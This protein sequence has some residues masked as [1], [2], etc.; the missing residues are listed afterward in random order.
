MGLSKAGLS[1]EEVRAF[2]GL[3]QSCK[4]M[5]Q[6]LNKRAPRCH[7]RPMFLDGGEGPYDDAWWECSHC[8]HT[9]TI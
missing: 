3:D 4:D 2:E 8:G 7:M 5:E 6:E 9:K 1:E